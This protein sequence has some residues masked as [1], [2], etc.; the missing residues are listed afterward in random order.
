MKY[1]GNKILLL[2][3]ILDPLVKILYGADDWLEIK[4][5]EYI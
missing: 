5:K 2:N 4:C 1:L 3:D